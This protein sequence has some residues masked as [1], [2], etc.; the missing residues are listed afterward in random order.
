M[1]PTQPA[2]PGQRRPSRQPHPERSPGKNYSAP[3]LL[4]G[5]RCRQRGRAN[6]AEGLHAQPRTSLGKSATSPRSSSRISTTADSRKLIELS[7]VCDACVLRVFPLHDHPS[8]ASPHGTP[9]YLWDRAHRLGP[10]KL[11]TGARTATAHSTVL[12]GRVR[13]PAPPPGWPR[14]HSQRRPGPPL[15][16]HEN[17]CHSPWPDHLPRNRRTLSPNSLNIFST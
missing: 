16:A 11:N 13:W 12:S 2:H 5:P 10:I 4:Q 15:A 3:A 6:I 17:H 1:L 14:K 9:R 7:S 8:P